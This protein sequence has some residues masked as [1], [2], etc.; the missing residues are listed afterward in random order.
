MRT[1]S[2]EM[3][4]ATQ[5]QFVVIYI[6]ALSVSR[7]AVLATNGRPGVG[8]H[9]RLEGLF[10]QPC[11]LSDMESGHMI[12]NSDVLSCAQI[13][14]LESV[15]GTTDRQL[16]MQ[17]H[18]PL[19]KELL[20]QK[21]PLTI[22]QA[23]TGSGKSML[24]PTE[25]S[26]HIRRKLLVLNPSTIDTE[27][28]CKLAKC[29]SCFRMG[30]KRHGGVDFAQAK[31]VF[32]TVGLAAQWYTSHGT[33][34]FQDYDGVFC[35]EMHD[36]EINP[37]YSMLWE[38]F[39]LIARSRDI[40]IVGA[41]A[42]FSD[43]MK[44]TLHVMKTRW[45]RC[46]ERPYHLER[47]RVTV[48]NVKQLYE[49]MAHMTAAIIQR[50]ESCLL[51]LPGKL[52]IID[53]QQTLTEKKGIRGTWTSQLHAEL[54]E[55]Q[56]AEALKV[57][58][59]PK[60]ILAT[61]MAETSITLPQI[62]HVLDSGLCRI[63]QAYDD[64]LNS[65][66]YKAPPSVQAQRQGRAGRVKPG[67]ATTF[68]I[69]DRSLIPQRLPFSS[70]SCESVVVLEKHHLYIK[71]QNM[72]MCRIPSELSESIRQRIQTL[73]LSEDQLMQALIELPFSLR[74]AAVLFKSIQENGS[75]EVAALLIFK[76]TC[77]WPGKMRF[78][79]SDIV[80]AVAQPNKNLVPPD[81]NEEVG[82]LH[83]ARIQFT[84]LAVT[85]HKARRPLTR[86]PWNASETEEAAAVAFLA[87]PERLV[88][89][90][91]DQDPACFL[92]E[93]LVDCK[94]EDY[95]VGVLFRKSCKGLQCSLHLPFTEWV[96][97]RAHIP[98]FSKT[99]KLLSDSTLFEFRVACILKL[100]SLGYD[101]RLWH[102]QGGK[103]E[104][105]FAVDITLSASVGLCIIFPNG[106][107]LASQQHY[108]K[109][110]WLGRCADEIAT[111]LHATAHAAVA[112]VGDAILSPGVRYTSAYQKLGLFLLY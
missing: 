80:E 112:F 79:L 34:L 10:L 46:P 72:A 99:A 64:I 60:V 8:H 101:M 33:K 109:P 77:T 100:R 88:W 18:M 111:A 13:E 67:S 2:I 48:F 94:E 66:D 102:C 20:H 24:I 92:G 40:L 65:Q 84:E 104:T 21:Q 86:S 78:S 9:A 12:R 16:P 108:R 17:K 53:M 105:E 106:N 103:Q 110:A 85:L 107:R 30:G 26:K 69:S 90:R 3:Y 63:I 74:D 73:S 87:C 36:M 47:N 31:I 39:L 23:A 54:G 14:R 61:S 19:L 5:G 62:E 96:S 97:H 59:H 25:M 41:S 89:H 38:V 76:N 49:A 70:E 82:R 45:V 42:T 93:K 51:F 52:E 55:N 6:T 95:S 11:L 50:G 27:N 91:G 15:P 58:G 98:K 57:V 68:V 35:D 7:I 22:V 56:I 43:Q 81:T 32:V 83:K 37:Q 4:A 1:D 71:A 29:P 75:Y 44:E 28:V